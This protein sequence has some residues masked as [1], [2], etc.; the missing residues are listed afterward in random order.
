MQHDKKQS[1]DSGNT[2]TLRWTART[3][4][5]FWCG[6]LSIFMFESAMAQGDIVE[7]ANPFFSA[8]GSTRLVMS[9]DIST[10]DPEIQMTAFLALIFPKAI[11]DSTLPPSSLKSE[12]EGAMDPAGHKCCIQQAPTGGTVEAVQSNGNPVLRL[13]ASESGDHWGN[14]DLTVAND[15]TVTGQSTTTVAG[16]SNVTTT[17]SGTLTE[18]AIHGDFKIGANG[19]L[20]NGVP[21]ILT[22]NMANAT[23]ERWNFLTPL[24]ESGVPI[25][26]LFINDSQEEDLISGEGERVRIEVALSANGSSRQADWWLVATT[27]F[28]NWFHY[29]LPAKTWVPGLEPTYQGPVFDLPRTLISDFPT[30]LPVTEINVIMGL[31]LD[32]NGIV[33]SDNLTA[34]VI[35]AHR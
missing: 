5:R 4:H 32:Q 31:D 3:R 34:R 26:Q 13:Q 25:P 33:D 15:G 6:I 20:P 22:M 28:Q 35:K 18:T 12:E 19:G 16:F 11:L 9:L 14:M 29:D 21:A 30:G 17:F 23:G 24:S 2:L 1:D 7:V 8:I 10:K 27:D